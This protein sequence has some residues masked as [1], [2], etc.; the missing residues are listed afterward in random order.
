MAAVNL[1]EGKA[2]FSELVARAEAG[3][4]VIVARRG[5]PVAKLVPVR[6]PKVVDVESLRRH[7]AKMT[8]PPGDSENF[9][10]ELRDGARY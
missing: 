5:K 2:R 10:R 7:L 1:A 3:E 4:E 9:I 6:M 8:S